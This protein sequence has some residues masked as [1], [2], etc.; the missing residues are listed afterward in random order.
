MFQGS[1]QPFF[2]VGPDSL[3][4]LLAFRDFDNASGLNEKKPPLKSWEKHQQDFLQA[5]PTLQGGRG[6]GLIGAINYLSNKGVNSFSFLT[7]NVDGDGAN[8]WPHI[9]PTD[10]THFDCSKLEQW[11][12]VFKHAQSR[13]LLLHFKLKETENDDWGGA[14]GAKEI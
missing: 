13:G 8:V 6:K 1:G 14:R 12:I 3:E 11:A 10:K 2:K 9:S 7:Y 4:T 5:D